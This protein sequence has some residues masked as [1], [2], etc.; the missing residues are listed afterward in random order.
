MK[1]KHYI[2]QMV[3]IAI[4][5]V[6][7]DSSDN[8]SDASKAGNLASSNFKSTSSGEQILESEPLVKN[9]D[10][11]NLAPFI[12]TWSGSTFPAVD[13]ANRGRF[14]IEN[15]CVVVY[16][17]RDPKPATAIFPEK[18]RLSG[19]N[20]TE[21]GLALP[22]G[23]NLKLN[24]QYVFSGDAAE[25]FDPNALAAPIPSQCPKTVFSIGDI[26]P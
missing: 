14:K 17:E 20:K 19:S 12:A 10:P 13:I 7:C 23:Q 3:I 15:G 24:V 25:Q 1:N 8:Q 22:N 11:Q 6:G 9:A 4:A 18:T 2:I 26:T 21:L 5:L 16:H